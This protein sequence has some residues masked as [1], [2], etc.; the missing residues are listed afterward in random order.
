MLRYELGRG[1]E[2]VLRLLPAVWEQGAF[3]ARGILKD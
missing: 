1:A 2:K 3:R